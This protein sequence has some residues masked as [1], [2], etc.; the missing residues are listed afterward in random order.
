[1]RALVADLD[2][3]RAENGTLRAERQE[4]LSALTAVTASLAGRVPRPLQLDEAAGPPSARGSRPVSW[5]GRTVMLAPREFALLEYLLDH[6][7]EP[8]TRQALLGAVFP[9]SDTRSLRV[10]IT[11]VRSKLERLGPVPVRI[12]TVRGMGYRLD[13]L[14]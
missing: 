7:G 10:H 5:G 2:R 14:H 11:A 1:M 8:L 6:P 3:L 9:T 13:H 12:S 4:L